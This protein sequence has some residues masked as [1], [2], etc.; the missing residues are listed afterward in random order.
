MRGWGGVTSQGHYN[1][2][3]A[4]HSCGVFM[5]DG[6]F[7]WIGFLEKHSGLALQ[8]QQRSSEIYTRPP[9]SAWFSAKTTRTSACVSKFV[10]RLLKKCHTAGGERLCVHTCTLVQLV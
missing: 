10:L 5:S 7:G 9:Q 8:Y 6:L 4:H 1:S 3:R 2:L